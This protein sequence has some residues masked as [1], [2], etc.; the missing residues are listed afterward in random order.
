[1]TDEQRIARAVAVATSEIAV[2]LCAAAERRTGRPR[3]I[4]LPGVLAAYIFHAS[5][6][7]HTMTTSGVCRSLKKLKPKQRAALG[8]PKRMQVRYKRMH[9]GWRAIK[10]VVEHGVLVEH[11]H[12]LDVDPDT[13]EVLPC[14]E[15]CPFEQVGLDELT[16][17]AH[18]GQP[19][20]GV[21]A[22]TGGGH[23]RHRRREPY[24]AQEAHR[25][26]GPRVLVLRPRRPVGTPHRH[27]PPPHRALPRI[28]SHLA[29]YAP[30][31]G[32]DPSPR[33]PPASRCDR[34]SATAPEPA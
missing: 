24:P 32:S 18:P 1:M 9:S 4:P 8:I 6:E 2:K 21:R 17:A 26:R 13:G 20:A 34:G 3:L 5:G 14:P 12:D 29:T 11:D 10:R 22:T 16:D 19:P 25:R 28:R 23:R 7:P 30:R 27:R 31:V 33:S 15:G